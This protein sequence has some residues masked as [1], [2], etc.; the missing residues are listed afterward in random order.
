MYPTRQHAFLLATI[1][2][3]LLAAPLSGAGAAL[4]DD[5][6]LKLVQGDLFTN[7]VGSVLNVAVVNDT[8]NTVGSVGVQ[9]A[10]TAKGKPVGSAGVIIFNIV[11]GEKGQ[12]QVHLLGPKADGATCSITGTTPPAP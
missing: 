11:A 6:G 10:F 3:A 9:C 12:D 7:D 8:P 5:A 2:A 4:A 1:L